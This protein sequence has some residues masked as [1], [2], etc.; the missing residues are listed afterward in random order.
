MER[1][2]VL[3]WLKALSTVLVLRGTLQSGIY[4]KSLEGATLLEE[5]LSQGPEVWGNAF[6]TIVLTGW[7][8]L[9]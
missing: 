2:P 7:R 9:F 1:D 5:I 6:A 4:P 3:N 8:R